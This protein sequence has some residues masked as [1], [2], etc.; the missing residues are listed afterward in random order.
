V[1][2]RNGCSEGLLFPEL[3]PLKQHVSTLFFSFFGF[4][5]PKPFF[6]EKLFLMII[7]QFGNMSEHAWRTLR[8]IIIEQWLILT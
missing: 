7:G 1:I 6:G 3:I 5:Q 2:I 4:H 8:I